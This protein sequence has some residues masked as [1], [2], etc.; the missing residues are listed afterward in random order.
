MNARQ[1]NDRLKPSLLDRLIGAGAGVGVPEG[2][3]AGDGETPSLDTS[4][5]GAVSR[6]Q[7]R[8]SVARDLIWLL[9]ATRLETPADDGPGS[10]MTASAD[11]RRAAWSAAPLARA[12]VLNFGLPAMTGRSQ[13]SLD[14]RRLQR[15][16]V[17]AI[18]RFEPRILPASL[19][20]SLEADG[21]MG[22]RGAH[23]PLRLVIQGQLRHDPV[24]LTLWMAAELDLDTGHA[25]LRDLRG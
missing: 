21:S 8:E 25:R 18:Q 2:G 19:E 1:R 15:D 23:R 10:E 16:L 4:A 11:A 13:S 6:R 12:S 14:R 3:R 22:P 7:L 20:V 24:P 9:N 17:E 5:A